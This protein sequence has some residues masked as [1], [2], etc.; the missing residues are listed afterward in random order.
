MDELDLIRIITPPFVSRFFSRYVGPHVPRWVIHVHHQRAIRIFG[1]V[2]VLDLASGVAFG[3][4]DHVGMWNGIYFSIV[5]VTTVGY[6]DVT[7]HGWLAHLL[8]VTIMFLVLPLWGAM[9]SY[10]TAGITAGHAEKMTEKQTE[11]L[12]EHVN[13]STTGWRYPPKR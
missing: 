1:I 8:A 3:V 9:F 10:L 12:K 13:G 11:E 5:T 4:S 7:P 2:I 6:G